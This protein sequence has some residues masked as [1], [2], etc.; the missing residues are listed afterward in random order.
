MA[1]VDRAEPLTPKG[2]ISEI[3]IKSKNGKN[4]RGF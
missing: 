4:S 1:A 2:K 3:L